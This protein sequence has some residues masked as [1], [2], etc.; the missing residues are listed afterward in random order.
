MT[1]I[2][3]MD[4]GARLAA[5]MEG[6]CA[7]SP[8]L[9]L[10]S[11]GCTRSMWDAQV[12]TLATK[13]RVIRVDTRGHGESDAPAGPYTLDRLG[14]DALAILDHFDLPRAHICGLSLGGAIAQWLAIEAPDRIDRLV[15]ANTAARIGTVE[16]WQT[17]L[18]TV[19]SQGMA[20]IADA[21]LGRF[22]SDGTRERDPI[23]VDRFRRIVLDTSPEGYAGCCAALRDA[24]LRGSVGGITAPT[25]VIGGRLDVS[26]P[27]EQ[28]EALVAGIP[29]A[30]L[31]ALDT[32]H[33]S[34]IEAP[35][36]FSAALLHHL[37]VL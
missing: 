14:R 1:T 13:F 27:L 25:L 7:A 2:V 17:R 16:A 33:L 3:T 21:V 10:S 6:P 23:L 20:A 15:L 12:D 28:A 37:E 26:T 19:L 18:D 30:R 35:A 36:A 8:L 32:A 34:N 4:D 29:G 31:L 5:A 11:L 9:F 24:D 22:F